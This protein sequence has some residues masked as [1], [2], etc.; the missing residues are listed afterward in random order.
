[1]AVESASTSFEVRVPDTEE[2]PSTT[3]PS[4]WLPA[5]ITLPDASP[6][7]EVMTGLSLVPVKVTVIVWVS[8]EPK[9]SVTVAVNVSVTL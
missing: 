7:S 5:S 8:A 1:M 3:L 9:S 4:S 2:V 6:A